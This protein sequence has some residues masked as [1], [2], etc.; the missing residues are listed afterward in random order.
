MTDIA[1]DQSLAEAEAEADD[2][3][4]YMEI[5]DVEEDIEDTLF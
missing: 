2:D 4:A 5:E 3:S 1:I